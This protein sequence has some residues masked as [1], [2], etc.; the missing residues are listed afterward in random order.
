MEQNKESRN[1]SIFMC[2]FSLQEEIIYSR[3]RQFIQEMVLGK[4]DIFGQNNQT[5]PLWFTGYKTKLKI[6]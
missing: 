1:K 2:S 6:D 3:E 4:L 5:G